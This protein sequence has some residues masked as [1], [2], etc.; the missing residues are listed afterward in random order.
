MTGPDITIQTAPRSVSDLIGETMGGFSDSAGGVHTTGGVQIMA[1]HAVSLGTL[2]QRSHD[3][4][5]WETFPTAAGGIQWIDDPN[6]GLCYTRCNAPAAAAGIRTRKLWSMPTKLPTGAVAMAEP[7]W[8][9]FVVEFLLRHNGVGTG[10]TH[11]WGLSANFVSTVFAAGTNC[12][13][14][15]TSS[16][17]NRLYAIVRDNAIG[18]TRIDTGITPDQNWHRYTILVPFI[19]SGSQNPATGA[20]FYRDGVL[21]GTASI[22]D[23]NYPR[24]PFFVKFGHL[25]Q[26]AASISCAWTLGGY[27]IKR[28]N[29]WTP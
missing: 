17:P 4:A 23:A 8:S 12:I 18:E 7:P 6:V 21:V 16:G 5:K 25:T 24:G 10:D 9:S 14:F 11:F 1:D 15:L 20:Q 22:A 27:A 28:R 26:A 29:L 2:G 13:A 3:L 19:T